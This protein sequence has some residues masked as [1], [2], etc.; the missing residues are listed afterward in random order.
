MSGLKGEGF[1]EPRMQPE[2]LLRTRQ[3]AEML[4]VQE[5]T[6]EQWRWKGQ[7]PLFIKV[8]RLVRYRLADVE[9][10]TAARAYSSTTAAQH[11]VVA[12][13]KKEGPAG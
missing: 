8:G 9:S 10:F 7:G 1:A 2:M 6:L 4:Q 5:T 3:V 11:G 13:G 12:E